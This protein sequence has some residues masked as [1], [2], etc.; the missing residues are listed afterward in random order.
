LGILPKT[1]T[2]PSLL[3][4]SFYIRLAIS[5]DG[6]HLAT[7][8]GKGGVI[9]WSIDQRGDE[10]GRVSGTR[11]P[12]GQGGGWWPDH[13]EREVSAV[14]WGRDM[15]RITCKKW[16][17][18]LQLIGIELIPQPDRGMCGRSGDENMEK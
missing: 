1:Y 16:S 4:S 14:D 12:L 5:P 17:A 3:V 8:S 13:R 9:A 15:V 11:L 10:K 2:D 18:W 7:G 6:R